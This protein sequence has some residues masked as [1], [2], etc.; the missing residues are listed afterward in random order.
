MYIELLVAFDHNSFRLK[1]IFL[2]WVIYLQEY[3]VTWTNEFS[4][5][6]VDLNKID[7]MTGNYMKVKCSGRFYF[8]YRILF[9]KIPVSHREVKYFVVTDL[10]APGFA[11]MAFIFSFTY[12]QGGI[13]FP[14]PLGGRES[15]S[16]LL[17]R[18]QGNIMAVGKKLTWKKGKW[19]NSNKA[20]EYQVDGEEG[21][22]RKF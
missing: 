1:L 7:M 2:P 8:F 14:L 20:E 10:S 17:S 22:G 5:T 21:N 13:K 19:D 18:G 12:R 6:F 9:T 3:I 11:W 15:F 16:S 4:W